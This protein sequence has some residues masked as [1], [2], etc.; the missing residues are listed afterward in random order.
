MTA[1]PAAP[2]GPE[3]LTADELIR[4]QIAT[5]GHA[6]DEFRVA[7]VRN[8]DPWYT[9]FNVTPDQRMYLPPEKRVRVW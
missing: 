4:R 2:P 3:E 6:P 7:T 1:D 5:D 9:T 8:L